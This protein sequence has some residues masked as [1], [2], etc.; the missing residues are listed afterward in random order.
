M[1]FE[2]VLGYDQIHKSQKLQSYLLSILVLAIICA[3]FVFYL[4]GGEDRYLL[5]ASASIICM[6]GLGLNYLYNFIKKYNKAF[7]VI[8]ILALLGWGTYTQVNFA[9]ELI[10]SKKESFLQMR[11]GFEWIRDNTPKESIILG[12]GI[13]AYAIYYAERQYERLSP[14]ITNVNEIN[15]DYLVDHA[16]TERAGYMDEYIQKNQDKWKPIQVFFIDKQQK[17]PIFIVYEKADNLP[18]IN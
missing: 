3:F 5:A 11:Q 8:I 2:S 4:R 18:T 9:D 12:Q 17:Q 14:N 10:K 7:A 15:A 1:L 6:T 16:F 13:E